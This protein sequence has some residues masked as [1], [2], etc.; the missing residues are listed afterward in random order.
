M[1]ASFSS[2]MGT[3][4]TLGAGMG[5]AIMAKVPPAFLAPPPPAILLLLLLEHPVTFEQLTLLEFE[6][7]AVDEILPLLLPAAY[8]AA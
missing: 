2:K 3:F 7:S 6:P 4:L 5:R 8:E 1:S